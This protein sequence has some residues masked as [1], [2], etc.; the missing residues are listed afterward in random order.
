ME[1]WNIGMMVT[2]NPF[3]G[4]SGRPGKVLEKAG[5]SHRSFNVAESKANAINLGTIKSKTKDRA[6]SASDAQ[7]SSLPLFLARR[8]SGR[9]KKPFVP[10]ALDPS[11]S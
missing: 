3:A 1:H 8:Y 2:G 11:E 10:D 6:I 9:C 7:Y 5:L 4:P